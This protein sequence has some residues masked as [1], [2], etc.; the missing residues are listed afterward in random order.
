MATL[1]TCLWFDREAE[2]AAKFYVSVFPNSRI[3]GTTYYPDGPPDPSRAGSVLTV[4]FVLEGQEFFALNGGPVYKFTPA[5]S[6]VVHCDTQEEVDRAWAKL[7]D[8]GEEV[9]CGWLT[10]R[11]GVS[12][13]VVPR[14]FEQMLLSTDKAAVQRALSAMLPMR[15]LDLPTLR[16]AFEDA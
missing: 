13:Q 7:T 9:Q 4:N 8:G 12:W 11:Y 1:G 10:D 16:K 6:I 3:T 15:K 2:E 14:E 5:I